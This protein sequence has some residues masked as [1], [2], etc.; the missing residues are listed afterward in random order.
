MS[1]KINLP[2]NGNGGNNTIKAEAD[3][4]TFATSGN[5]NFTGFNFEGGT[6]NPYYPPGFSNKNPLNGQGAEV[7][8]SYD[9]TAIPAAGYTFEYTTDGTTKAGNGSG[10]IKNG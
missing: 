6:T 3:T 4:I 10:T 5:C 1:K 2:C 9:G 7:S 8:Y